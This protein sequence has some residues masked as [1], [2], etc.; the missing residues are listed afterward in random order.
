MFGSFDFLFNFENHKFNE[1]FMNLKLKKKKNYSFV[2]KKG[3]A[4][5]GCFNILYVVLFIKKNTLKRGYFTKE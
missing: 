5:I 3:R 2:D 1:F 4:L